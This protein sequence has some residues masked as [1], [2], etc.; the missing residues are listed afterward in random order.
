MMSV[1]DKWTEDERDAFY[2]ESWALGTQDWWDDFICCEFKDEWSFSD[3]CAA[4][5]TD[6]S[7]SC[8]LD[9]IKVKYLK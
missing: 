9:D 4:L 2:A 7:E 6:I 5:K 1:Y 8:K 3:L